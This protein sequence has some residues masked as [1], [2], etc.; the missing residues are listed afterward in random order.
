MPFVSTIETF[1]IK[2]C[3]IK[4]KFVF[5]GQEEPAAPPPFELCLLA[6]VGNKQ[7]KAICPLYQLLK[8]YTLKYA[9]FK[10]KCFSGCRV[11]R[12]TF[13]SCAP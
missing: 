12:F 9:T 4:I 5:Q 2:I 7:L 8:Y 3:Y 11:Y 10:K 13:S 1:Y 6:Q